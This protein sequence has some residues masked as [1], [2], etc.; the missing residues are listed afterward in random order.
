MPFPCSL[1][2]S[3]FCHFEHV[4]SCC[5]NAW[6]ATCYCYGKKKKAKSV[7]WNTICWYI[8]GKKHAWLKIKIPI[9]HW[10]RMDHKKQ[11]GCD[12]WTE[13]AAPFYRS[14]AYLGTTDAPGFLW[15]GMKPEPLLLKMPWCWAP[16]C[17][18]SVNKMPISCATI[19]GE[20]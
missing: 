17:V 20:V 15:S 18:W 7:S 8:D 9:H 10:M 1:C 5:L 4:I 19:H 2:I 11:T 12:L 16:L 3:R 14:R 13:E 6:R